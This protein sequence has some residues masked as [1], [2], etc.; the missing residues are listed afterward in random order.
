MGVDTYARDE[1]KSDYSTAFAYRLDALIDKD[2]RWPGVAIIDMMQYVKHIDTTTILTVGDLIGSY[3]SR[4]KWFFNKNPHYHTVI[5]LVDRSVNPIKRLVEYKKRYNNRA[6]PYASDGAPYLSS[7]HGDM[8]PSEWGRFSSNRELMQREFFPRLFNAFMDMS[9]P[10]GKKLILNGFPGRTRYVTHY[11]ARRYAGDQNA[12]QQEVA[13]WGQGELPITPRMEKEDPDL[14]NRVYMSSH[15]IPCEEYPQGALI[16]TEWEEARNAIQEADHS[17][18][19][20]DHFYRH[21]DIC[22][23]CNDGDVLPYGVLYA[24]ERR[25]G[26]DYVNKHYVCLP[27]KKKNEDI[28]ATFNGNVPDN[29]YVSLNKLHKLIVTDETMI[30]AGVQNKALFYALLVITT[31]SDFFKDFLKVSPLS[32][33]RPRR[34]R[35]LLLL[36]TL[37]LSRVLVPRSFGTHSKEQWML[38][39]TWFKC[40]LG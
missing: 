29:E 20:F 15:V 17:M 7:N 27:Y 5:L 21:E 36:L 40:P 23:Y 30:K 16:R 37:L 6:P 35:T 13:L 25:V 11:A 12:R 22:I 24:E 9:I 38:H 2:S 33:W 1:T 4:I 31:G 18:F 32:S 26:N 3:V 39:L 28:N 8:L 19:Y 10:P 34:G 14:Y